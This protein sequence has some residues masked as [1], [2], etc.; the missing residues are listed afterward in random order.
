M[1]N[2]CYLTFY[3]FIDCVMMTIQRKTKEKIM[4]EGTKEENSSKTKNEGKIHFN[5]FMLNFSVYYVE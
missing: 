3:V 5:N 4:N 1:S 2:I